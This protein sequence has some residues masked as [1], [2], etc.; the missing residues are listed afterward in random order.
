M[1]LN[2][3]KKETI[4]KPQPIGF[5]CSA[6]GKKFYGFNKKTCR[7]CIPVYDKLEWSKLEIR[8]AE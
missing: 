8:G 5:K 4:E 2:A 3:V 6:D 7:Y 1:D